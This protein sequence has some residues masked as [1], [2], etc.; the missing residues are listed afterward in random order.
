MLLYKTLL[1]YLREM[2]DTSA[3]VGS[4]IN[5]SNFSN[6]SDHSFCSNGNL[7]CSGK[8]LKIF[9]F[10]SQP[11]SK[12]SLSIFIISISCL[13]FKKGRKKLF[14]VNGRNSYKND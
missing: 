8:H 4:C 5:N 2:T 14:I 6:Y 1:I 10:N 12:I 11:H 3:F 9:H 13:M 7:F